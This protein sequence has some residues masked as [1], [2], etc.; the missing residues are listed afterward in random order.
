MSEQPAELVFK[1]RAPDSGFRRYLENWE[2]YFFPIAVG[3]MIFIP[4]DMHPYLLPAMVAIVWSLVILVR[5]SLRLLAGIR[6]RIVQDIALP[7]LTLLLWWA[8]IAAQRYSYAQA[9]E[10]AMVEARVVQDRCDAE[11][12]CPARIEAWVEKP[13]WGRNLT[14]AGWSTTYWL[15]YKRS[16]DGQSFAIRVRR[17]I[18]FGDMIHAGV[19]REPAW[20]APDDS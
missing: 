14:K 4:V 15:E 12:R 5:S 13:Q 16:E 7:I 18:D 8:G 17:D 10:F 20:S 1:P 3:A 19:G 2:R 6:P 11:R 9:K